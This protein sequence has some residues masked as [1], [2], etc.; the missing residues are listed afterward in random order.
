SFTGTKALSW[1][2]SAD[3]LT[4]RWTVKTKGKEAALVTSVD[5]FNVT[6]IRKI[7]V[8]IKDNII[9]TEFYVN[10]NYPNPFNPSTTISF[11][12]PKESFVDLRIYNV[13]GQEV[14]VLIGNQLRQAGNIQVKFDAS[15]FA[16]GTYIY[17]LKADNQVVVKKMILMK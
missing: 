17:R 4:T 8:G 13:L 5:T 16:S 6:F 11:G 2:G 14:A 10:Q 1:M 7:A 12:L 15:V 3:T 9:P